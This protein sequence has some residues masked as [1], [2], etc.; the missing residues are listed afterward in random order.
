[1]WLTI[2]T[3]V[4]GAFVGSLVAAITASVEGYDWKPS[5]Q[6]LVLALGFFVGA[7]SGALVGAT[8]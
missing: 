8:A 2:A 5:E 6:R 4:L 3:T 7:I 1:M